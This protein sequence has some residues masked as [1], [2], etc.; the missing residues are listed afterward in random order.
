MIYLAFSRV[1]DVHAQD[2]TV[3]D[4][5]LLA[6]PNLKNIDALLPAVVTRLNQAGFELISIMR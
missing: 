1:R 5:Y 3:I 2:P 6:I 4:Y